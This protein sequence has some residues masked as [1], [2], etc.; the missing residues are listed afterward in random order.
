MV[1]DKN[2]LIDRGKDIEDFVGYD[3]DI[4]D[5]LEY[6]FFVFEEGVEVFLL[7]LIF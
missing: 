3:E 2:N 4:L 6:G 7:F 5:K 1:R